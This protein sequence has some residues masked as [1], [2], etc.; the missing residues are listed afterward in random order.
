MVRRTWLLLFALLNILRLYGVYVS[1]K[2]LHKLDQHAQQCN[3]AAS[4]VFKLEF[5]LGIDARALSYH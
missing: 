3:Q 2:G 5:G 4:R 1:L